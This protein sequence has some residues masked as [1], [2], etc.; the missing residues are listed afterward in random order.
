MKIGTILGVIAAAAAVAAIAI[1]APARAEVVAG[2]PVPNVA[3]VCATPCAPDEHKGLGATAWLLMLTGFFGLGAML[4]AA[5]PA[6]P[7]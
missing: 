1:A 6:F 5:R 7:D 4:R 3:A 2:A